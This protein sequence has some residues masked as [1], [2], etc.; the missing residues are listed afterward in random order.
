M[1]RTIGARELKTH[2]GAV[3][4]RAREHQEPY[5]VTHRGRVVAR[6]VPE[7]AAPAT[8]GLDAWWAELDQLTAEIGRRWPEGVSAMQA[9]GQDRDRLG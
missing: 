2:L 8:A 5:A 7:P 9:I 4:R 1:M 3:L 6:L